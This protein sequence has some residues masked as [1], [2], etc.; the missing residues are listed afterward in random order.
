V[1]KNRPPLDETAGAYR[2]CVPLGGSYILGRVETISFIC[3]GTASGCSLGAKA[4]GVGRG[5]GLNK[6]ARVQT[7]AFS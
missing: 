5:G 4:N 3:V 2:D 7:G 1:A 6:Q